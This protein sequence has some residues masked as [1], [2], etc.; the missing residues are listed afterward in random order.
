MS[1]EL[2]PCPF[3]GSKV[4][5]AESSEYMSD[6]CD[7]FVYCNNCDSSWL[8]GSGWTDYTAATLVCKWN[9]RTDGDIKKQI[10][11]AGVDSAYLFDWYISSVPETDAPVW[12]EEHI[13]ELC[14]D[15]YLIPK[16]E[17]EAT[18]Q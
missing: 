6:V 12:T 15:F 14:N 17:T 10:E 13:D 8:L 11:A 2:K 16:S 5:I 3:C 9:Q 4:E 18:D 7:Y 1:E